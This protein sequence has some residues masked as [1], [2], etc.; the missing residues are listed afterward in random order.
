MT[1]NDNIEERQ[2]DVEELRAANACNYGEK[3]ADEVFEKIDI[4]IRYI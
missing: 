3:T 4:E 1:L 2:A